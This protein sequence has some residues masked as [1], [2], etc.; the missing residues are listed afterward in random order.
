MEG[1][2]TALQARLQGCGGGGCG[3]ERWVWHGWLW[4]IGRWCVRLW[5]REE[6]GDDEAGERDA[7]GFGSRDEGAHG[8]NPKTHDDAAAI[9]PAWHWS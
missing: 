9:K 4:G 2:A 6:G 8:G 7:C 1:G 5:Q 3:T